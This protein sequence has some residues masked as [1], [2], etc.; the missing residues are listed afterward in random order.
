VNGSSSSLLIVLVSTILGGGFLG[1]I[2]A[3]RK[4][5]PETDQIIVSSAKGVVAIQRET[6]DEMRKDRADDRQRMDELETRFTAQA[7]EAARAAALALA[8][9]QAEREE[10][11]TE[12]DAARA[13]NAEL[14][15][16]IEHLEAEVAQMRAG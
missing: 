1:G 9:C 4:L 8:A 6:L 14:R 11:R 16:R 5:K 13:D 7:A 3:Y 10:A 15:K 2:V 12:R